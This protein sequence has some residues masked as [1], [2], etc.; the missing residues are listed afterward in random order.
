[1]PTGLDALAYAGANARMRALLA[2]LLTDEQWR[3]LV[4][5]DSPES[6]LSLLKASSYGDIFG[7][8]QGMD[9]V[10][11]ERVERLLAGRAAENCL[12]V[13]ALTRT[14]AR[15]LLFTWWQHFELEN[16][17]AVFRGVEQGL[18]PDVMRDFLIP[19]QGP[20]P[21]PWEALLH[22]TTIRGLVDL[23]ADTH[24][25]NPLRNALPLYERGYSLFALEVA[26][27][28]R[29]YRDIAAGILRL[30][31]DEQK[32]VRHLLGYY[33]DMLNILWAFRYRVYYQ[34][35][36]EEIVNFTLWHTFHTDVQLVR[37]IALGATPAEVVER[38]WGVGTLDLSPLAQYDSE[39][40]MLPVLELIL[41][42][43][44]R[45]RAKAQLSGYP[46]R[47]AALLGYLILEELEI[48]DLVTLLEA[49]GMGWPPEHIREH[50]LRSWE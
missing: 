9:G 36:A 21:L 24:Y 3:D 30:Q 33:L 20:S 6:V 48:Q 7:Q 44:W 34:M 46:F 42:R 32:E 26:V 10:S 39:A 1:M 16:L 5:A 37:D 41:Y 25:V 4:R 19:L 2:G 15:A 35:S 23:L 45:H 12:K 43:H 31:G 14:A 50:L 17:K 38:V 22:E 27:D 11:L 40:D 18:S 29:Y 8:F 49:K 47:L 28:I 13:M